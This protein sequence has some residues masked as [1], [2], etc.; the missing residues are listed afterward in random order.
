M[1]P[2]RALQLCQK[3]F[4]SVACLIDEVIPKMP[5]CVLASEERDAEA[6]GIE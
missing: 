3:E 5:I 4:R 1:V 6:K 2:D